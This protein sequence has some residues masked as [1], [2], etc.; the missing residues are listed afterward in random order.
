MIRNNRLITRLAAAALLLAA[1]PLA[2]ADGTTAGQSVTNT[3]TVNYS[4]GGNAQD[5]I[6]SNQV[7][8]LVDRLVTYTVTSDDATNVDIS[9]N[10][11]AMLTFTVT[12]N[13][14]DTLDFLLT[15]ENNGA[16]GDDFDTSG[17]QVFVESGANAGYQALEDTLTHVDEL[18]ADD[19]VVV[20]VFATAPGGLSSGD[21][22]SVVLVAQAA[23]AATGIQADGTAGA[24]A[25]GTPGTALVAST[26]DDPDAVDTVFGEGTAGPGSTDGE[27]DG[28][29]S[30]AGTYAAKAAAISVVKNYAVLDD[31]SGASYP[32]AYPV[33]G[34]T[35][36]YC[37]TV[38][39]GSGAEAAT[40]VV[41]SDPIPTNSSFVDGSIR[42][43]G[44]AVADAAA[45]EAAENT[46][47]T[48]GDTDTVND[49]AGGTTTAYDGS[50]VTTNEANLA[51][52]AATTTT[53]K[54]TID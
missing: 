44:S 33:P 35:L 16:G 30:A 1:S 21:L 46:G 9:P 40:N 27:D 14:N 6:D 50:K 26:S 2:F 42:V 34:A 45:C 11:S 17:F 48:V 28:R 41:V 54:V 52:G 12:N 4:V 20:Y 32:D 36:I 10:G 15:A 23:E 31:P 5:P 7:D 43:L 51:A 18:A 19:N 39:N 29:N 38:Q 49:G 22:A 8:F 53:F 37:I 25:T 47:T 13:S 3:A 24:G